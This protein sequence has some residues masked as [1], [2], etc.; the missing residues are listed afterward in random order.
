MNST[1]NEYTGT[2][3]WFKIKSTQKSY[4]VSNEKEHDSKVLY[5][6]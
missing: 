3:Q 2:F 1:I 4:N 5:A 6:Q